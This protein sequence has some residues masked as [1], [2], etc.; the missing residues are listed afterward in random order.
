MN[1][2]FIFRSIQTQRIFWEHIL[3]N[4]SVSVGNQR[5]FSCFEISTDRKKKDWIEQPIVLAPTQ[6]KPAAP[7]CWDHFRG[8]AYCMLDPLRTNNGS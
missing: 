3:G 2:F 6:L 4:E 8:K 1:K 7:S 5:P